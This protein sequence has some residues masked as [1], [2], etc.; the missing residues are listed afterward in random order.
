MKLFQ[1]GGSPYQTGL[2]MAGA[3]P[4]DAVLILGASDPDFCA[5]I[6]AVTGLN[7]RTLVA[8]PSPEAAALLEAAGGRAGSLVESVVTPLHRLPPDLTAFDLAIIVGELAQWPEA[9]RPGVVHSAVGALRPGGRLILADGRRRTGLFAG[10]RSAPPQ[11]PEADV[12]RLLE[13]AGIK[14]VRRLANVNG[15][16]YWEGRH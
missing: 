11:L 5:E 4:G 8:D 7:G 3:R 6:A 10:L 12:R 9:E 2:A 14:A 16:A 13:G 1:P 15:I